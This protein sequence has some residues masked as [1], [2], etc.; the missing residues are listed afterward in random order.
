MWSP[1]LQ[2]K[3]Q[4]RICLL[5]KITLV[6]TRS[7]KNRNCF[8]NYNW[9][10]HRYT[11]S[12]LYRVFK[13]WIEANTDFFIFCPQDGVTCKIAIRIIVGAFC[14]INNHS[15]SK[16]AR[17]GWFYRAIGLFLHNI[18]TC[19]RVMLHAVKH[20]QNQSKSSSVSL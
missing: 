6:V 17:W 9:I 18:W 3:R 2:P 20:R 12:A 10:R 16:L 8:W 15:R 11:S 19:P 1:C 13:I 7:Q 5:P 4:T 14:S